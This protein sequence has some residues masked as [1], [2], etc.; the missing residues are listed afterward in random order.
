MYDFVYKI[1]E[2]EELALSVVLN[3]SLKGGRTLGEIIDKVKEGKQ[4]TKSGGKKLLTDI[5]ENKFPID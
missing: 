3:S 2:T 4:L 1:A 5:I